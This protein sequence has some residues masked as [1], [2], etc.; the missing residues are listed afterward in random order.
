ML[1]THTSLI[2]SE[3]KVKALA[4]RYYRLRPSLTIALM[5]WSIPFHVEICRSVSIQKNTPLCILFVGQWRRS[6]PMANL[7]C[8]DAVIRTYAPLL[9]AYSR[10][11]GRL[12]DG[13]AVWRDSVSPEQGLTMTEREY[14]Y[15]IAACTRARDEE[16]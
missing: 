6:I 3:L 13:M 9:E 2:L 14:L 11:D 4:V 8:R 15:L 7:Q 12:Q 10:L 5:L 16:W 1:C